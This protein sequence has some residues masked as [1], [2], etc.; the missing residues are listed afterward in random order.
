[1][2]EGQPETTH[3]FISYTG[4]DRSWAE[5]IAW[6][7]EQAAYTTVIQAWDFGAGADFVQAMDEAVKKA[8]R[9]IAVLSPDYFQS[10]FAP[11]EW[12]A[13]FRRDPTGT[14]RLLV[15]V[16]VREYDVDGLL[17]GIV[18]I[19]LVG[20]AEDTARARLLA[21]VRHERAKPATQ[22]PFP[23]QWAAAAPEKPCFPGALPAVWNVPHQ[24]NRNFT[25]RGELLAALRTALIAEQPVTS[26]LGRVC[27][28]GFG[29]YISWYE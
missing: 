27:K 28:V 16:R 3:F 25:G 26:I 17:G 29:L 7:L 21:G 1:M 2:T 8:E 4:A 5:W 23:Q 12:H 24:R 19:D 18:Y 22:P 13:A 9:T 10:R 11:A 14:Q 15:P 20:L 6:V